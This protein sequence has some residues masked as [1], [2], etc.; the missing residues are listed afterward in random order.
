MPYC[1][2]YHGDADDIEVPGEF[3]VRPLQELFCMF[4]WT[5]VHHRPSPMRLLRLRPVLAPLVDGF[6]LPCRT[7][8]HL[9]RTSSVPGRSPR[10]P[11]WKP[12]HSSARCA[13]LERLP[14]AFGLMV[15]GLPETISGKLGI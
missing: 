13:F 2:H 5:K 10:T 9:N 4:G 12:Q 1:E 11:N 3:A 15:L 14:F 6:G 7:E 8:N